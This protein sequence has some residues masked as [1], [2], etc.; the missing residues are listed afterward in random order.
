MEDDPGNDR[1][2]HDLLDIV[3]QAMGG[4]G[5]CGDAAAALWAL[6]ICCADRDL[7][8]KTKCPDRRPSTVAHKPAFRHF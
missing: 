1:L 6:D 7:R 8:R 3:R 4:G 5:E 2:S